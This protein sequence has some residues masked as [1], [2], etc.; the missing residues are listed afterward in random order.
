MFL[1]TCEESSDNRKYIF[2]SGV[3]NVEMKKIWKGSNEL[4]KSYFSFSAENLGLSLDLFALEF[5]WSCINWKLLSVKDLFI[6]KLCEI[7]C[8]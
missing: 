4:N 7:Y 6:K 5:L 1:Q 8:L 3:N 2:L